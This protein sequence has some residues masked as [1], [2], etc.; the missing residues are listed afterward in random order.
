VVD[1]AER[2]PTRRV[3][4]GVPE[5][6]VP[7]VSAQPL[8]VADHAVEV[9]GVDVQVHAVRG[10]AADDLHLERTVAVRRLQRGELAVAAAP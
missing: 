1:E 2:Q 9:I 3:T 4:G 10:R 7:N 8:C 5:P 6:G